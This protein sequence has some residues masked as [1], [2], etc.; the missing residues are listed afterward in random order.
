MRALASSS[1]LVIALAG[2]ASADA[3]S[4]N[5]RDRD[6]SRLTSVPAANPKATGVAAPNVL[7]PELIETVGRPGLDAAREP[8]GRPLATARR[9]P[10]S[11]RLRR[12]RPDGAGARRRASRRRTTSRPPRPSPTRTPTWCSTA[13]TGAD[14]DY[15]YGTH[16][17]FQGHESAAR[18]R[19][20]ALALITRINLDADGAHRVTLLADARRARRAAPDDRRLDLGSVR[21][22]APL[23]DRGRR[24][25]AACWQATLDFPSHGRGPLR[26][27]RP[28]RLRGHP[29]RRRRQPLDRRGRRR[30]RRAR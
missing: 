27:V 20:R 25:A 10:S 2:T 8:G 1:I 19:G 30:R 18:R 7:S 14:P 5:H 15:D 29:E 11:L 17:L 9:S 26:R 4:E 21:A 28:R 13:Q 16:F 22:A 12:R 6:H 23:H 24:R 3:L